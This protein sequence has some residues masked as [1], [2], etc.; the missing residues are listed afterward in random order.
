MKTK[1]FTLLQLII[2]I[3]VVGIIGALLSPLKTELHIKIYGII[4]SVVVFLAL[5]TGVLFLH[6][7]L[8]RVSCSRRWNEE[9]IV[10]SDRD[11]PAV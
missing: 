8:E 4:W 5:L 1:G 6:E 9:T 2:V 7:Y 3:I 10:G 11:S